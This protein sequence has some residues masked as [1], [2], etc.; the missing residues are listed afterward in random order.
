MAS[1]GYKQARGEKTK[2]EILEVALQLFS[3]KGYTNVTVEEIVKISKT[4]KGSFYAH[5]GSKYEIFLEKFKEID[6]FYEARVKEIPANIP[7]KN[8]I[9]LFI[10]EQ[11]TFIE[12]ELGLELMRVI[13]SNA[14]TSNPH[15]YFLN[16]QRPLFMILR[17]FVD[18]CF[19]REEINEK[20]TSD[21]IMVII[22]SAM[23]GAIY[24]W[25]MSNAAFKLADE[26]E[27]LFK[28]IVNG[29]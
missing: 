11:M 27:K 14:L 21:E 3:D 23:F 26:S 25:S 2:K 15:D 5:F 9:V 12:N 28:T 10:K 7:A 1:K 29:L 16:H 8:K 22:N 13:Y 20:L 24:N 6:G 4:S 18:E 19:D 17:K